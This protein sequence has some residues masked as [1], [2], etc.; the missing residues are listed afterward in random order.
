MPTDVQLT[1]DSYFE[2]AVKLAAKEL[3]PH[4]GRCQLCEAPVDADDALCE[5]CLADEEMQDRWRR[6][7]DR[8]R[9]R[10]SI[11]GYYEASRRAI[12]LARIYRAE[13]ETTGRRE[14]EC[15]DAVARYRNEIRKLRLELS[16]VGERVG[17]PGLQKTRR[18]IAADLGAVIEEIG[19]DVRLRRAQ[20]MFGATTWEASAPM[21]M[22]RRYRA[23]GA[24][25]AEALIAL[26]DAIA[27][28]DAREDDDV[29]SASGH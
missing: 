25:P 7:S 24:T 22:E 18:T 15:L 20:T 5:E 12:T 14:R 8:R 17:G 28:D 26:R 1:L 19:D 29:R 16:G 23:H 9:A 2:E 10:E 4:P 3:E 21:A 13:P 6:Q 11:A 27:E